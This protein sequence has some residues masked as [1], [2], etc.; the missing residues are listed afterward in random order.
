MRVRMEQ[1]RFYFDDAEN[2]V[3]RIG[4][5]R[6]ATMPERVQLRDHF[7]IRAAIGNGK[8]VDPRCEDIF[9]GFVAQLEYFLD[10]LAFSFLERALL[11]TDL[12]Q[13]FE[14]FIGQMRASANVSGRDQLDDGGADCFQGATDGFEQRHYDAQ[15]ENA[16][17]G[18]AIRRRKCDKLG[19]QITEKNDDG[20]E[21]DRDQ[22]RW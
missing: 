5:D 19:K 2:V 8:H 3:G 14:F 10:H 21:R 1:K 4:V 20:K 7:L 11:S 16:E 9:R 13:G 18:K 12:N 6:N 17:S 15:S 22:P